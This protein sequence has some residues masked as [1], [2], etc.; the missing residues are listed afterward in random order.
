[1]RKRFV[2]GMIIVS[3]LTALL[4]TN[5]YAST[6]KISINTKTKKT[7]IAKTKKKSI[8]KTKKKSIAKTKKKII[9]A[10]IIEPV[11]QFIDSSFNVSDD[12]VLTYRFKVS[13]KIKWVQLVFNDD[14]TT[15]IYVKPLNGGY[16]N[17][18]CPVPNWPDST[19]KMSIN[20]TTNDNKDIQSDYLKV[21]QEFLQVNPVYETDNSIVSIQDSDLPKG[22]KFIM[23]EIKK[24]GTDYDNNVSYENKDGSYK[25]YLRDGAGNYSVD[26]STNN[27]DQQYNTW[28]SLYK[29]IKVINKDTRDESYLL[30]SPFVQSDDPQIIALANKITAGKTTDLDKIKA[31]HDW[32]ATN[33]A[34]DT[35]DYFSG[36]I[37]NVDCS[38]LAVLNSKQSICEGYADL[39]AALARAVGI[40]TKVIEGVA[41]WA[42]IGQRWQDVDTT[43]SN[44][45]WNEVNID[46]K[47]MTIDTTWDAGYTDSTTHTF[48]FNLRYQ[49]FN[50][51][52]ITFAI[53]HRALGVS[54]N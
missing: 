10:P 44:H 7:S 42:N 36:N 53:D 41:I 24:E 47:W 49:Y 12:N 40:P 38:S 20:E 23:E 48:T 19:E 50:P 28:Y 4:C 54:D 21:D 18:K 43:K 5:V 34:Y 35:V 30:P 29:N 52:A 37:D 51:D 9:I 6:L 39:F 3:V 8:A 13:R 33:I 17:E 25:I 1:M 2:K 22:T 27:S 45:A 14:L 16:V 32:V 46:S 15:A 11:D 26:I 31:I